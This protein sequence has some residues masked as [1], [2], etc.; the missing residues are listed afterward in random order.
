MAGLLEHRQ[1]RDHLRGA[2]P[3]CTCHRPQ[4]SGRLNR[5]A[6]TLLPIEITLTTGIRLYRLSA[7]CRYSRSRSP[8]P[9]SQLKKARDEVLDRSASSQVSV[10]DQHLITRLEH[11]NNPSSF[12]SGCTFSWSATY[13]CPKRATTRPRIQQYGGCLDRVSCEIFGCGSMIC[14]DSSKTAVLIEIQLN[15][16]LD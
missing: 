6:Y 7:L 10:R 4:A 3:V 13:L 11:S 16:Y 14:W 9:P 12:F 2:E 1:L 15:S 8:G 5:H